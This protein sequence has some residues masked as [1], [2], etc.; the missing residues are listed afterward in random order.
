ME[1]LVKGQK[2]EDVG[3]TVQDY[4]NKAKQLKDDAWK[5]EK[6]AFDM[7]VREVIDSGL[8]YKQCRHNNVK[9]NDGKGVFEIFGKLE[10]FMYQCQQ[11]EQGVNIHE[12]HIEG[13]VYY[14]TC[15]EARIVN[16]AA[17]NYGLDGS[18]TTATRFQD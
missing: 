16:M 7:T 12:C 5:C 8:I 4:I 17:T 18:I 1:Y 6:A 2:P 11:C 10:S 15:N 9:K 3:Y 14:M 13:E